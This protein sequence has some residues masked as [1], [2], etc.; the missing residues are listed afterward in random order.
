MPENA[1]A[2]IRQSELHGRLVIDV[3]TTE[4]LGHIAQLLVDTQNHQVEG[5]VCR[6]G[7]WGRER[8][9]VPWVQVESIGSDSVVVRRGSDRI[10]DR[11]DEAIPMEDKE[12][13]TDAGNRVGRLV[14]Y[15]ISPKTGQISQYLFTATEGL[16]L[17]DGI[18]LFTP[19]AVVSAGRKR[20]MVRQAALDNAPQYQGSLR[21]R[22]SDAVQ[23]DVTQTQQDFQSAV[24]STQ[25]ITYQVQ[26]QAKKLTEQ[27]RSRFGQVFGKLKQRS[28]QISEQ[29][30]DRFADLADDFQQPPRDRGETTQRPIDVDSAEVWPEDDGSEA[31]WPEAP[32]KPDERRDPPT[33][34]DRPNPGS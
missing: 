30:N 23:Q 1:A 28:R 6:A 22:A 33:P 21:D 3:E 14:D 19:D 32:D 11:F 7:F 13:W 24:Q 12:I 8:T 15:C 20:L 27:A 2:P 26:D 17:G 18:Y 25:E 34:E 31:D 29:V 10:S 5:L 4:E 9:P 16:A